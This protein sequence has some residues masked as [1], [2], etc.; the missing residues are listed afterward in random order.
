MEGSDECNGVT[1]EVTVDQQIADYMIIDGRIYWKLESSY[2]GAL[3]KT[4]YYNCDVGDLSAI[5]ETQMF[6]ETDAID[7]MPETTQEEVDAKNL[8]YGI[9]FGENI[10]REEEIAFTG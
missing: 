2:E 6:A 10:F 3:K 4:Q 5:N 9:G 8:K 1:Q 7:A